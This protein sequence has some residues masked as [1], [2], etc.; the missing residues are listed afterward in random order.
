VPKYFS[1]REAV[2]LLEATIPAKLDHDLVL[3]DIEEWVAAQWRDG[4]RKIT[5]RP[6]NNARLGDRIEV[7]P[8]SDRA[9]HWHEGAGQE[10][11][12]VYEREKP[13]RGAVTSQWRGLEISAEDLAQLK[14]HIQGLPESEDAPATSPGVE[15][16]LMKTVPRNRRGGR[17][18]G[19]RAYAAEDAPLI[20]EMRKAIRDAKKAGGTLPVRTAAKQVAGRAA[21]SGNTTS[22]DSKVTRLARAYKNPRK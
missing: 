5:G 9:I 2:S 16:A 4:R 3:F 1:L 12:R 21:P 17:P 13:G 11:P 22:F 7:D 19:A 20:K 10:E 8:H 18:K 14:E 15:S 6:W